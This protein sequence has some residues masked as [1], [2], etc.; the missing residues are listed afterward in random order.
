MSCVFRKCAVLQRVNDPAAK[1]PCPKVFIFP[2]SR[3]VLVVVNPNLVPCNPHD[4]I[5]QNHQGLCVFGLA[6]VMGCV[7]EQLKLVPSRCQG[8]D[9]QNQ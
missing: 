4:R 2:D 3:N 9:C 7:L 5:L 1:F 6:R 8:E